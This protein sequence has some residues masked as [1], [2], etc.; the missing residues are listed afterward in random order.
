MAHLVSLRSSLA[1]LLVGLSV[2]LAAQ[3]KPSAQDADVEALMELLNTP[4]KSASKVAQRPMDA[5]SII[6]PVTQDQLRT[7]GWDSINDVLYAQPGFSPSQD[8]DRRTVTARGM[9][10]GWNNNHLLMLIDGV[11]MND[12]LYGTA[13]TWEITPIFMA[14]SLEV[15]RGPGSAL[16]GSNATNG[17]VAI[18]TVSAEEI[19]KPGE[20]RIRMG[21]RQGRQLDFVV[22]SEGDVFSLVAAYARN[23]TN[24][25]EYADYDWSGRTDAAGRLAKFQTWD[26]RSNDYFLGKLEGRGDLKG[27]SFQY[28]H[29][30]WQFGT[31][32]GWYFLTPDFAET[33]KE[34][35]DILVGAY[36][37]EA[38]AWSQEYVLRFQRHN[39]DWNQRYY[40][41][42]PNVYAAGLWEYLNTSADEVFG[43]AQGTRTF[44]KGGSLV[45]GLE[46]SRFSYDGDREHNSNVD[47]HNYD[48]Q[49]NLNPNAYYPWDASNST[50][51][52]RPWLEW[53]KDH[54]V[55]KS[56]LYAQFS[57]GKLLN[58]HFS[59]TLGVRYDKQSSEFTGI[60]TPGRPTES[61]SYSRVSPRLAFIYHGGDT[62]SLKLLAGQAFRTPAP[63]ET[64]GANTFSLASNIR[65]LKPEIIDTVEL[66]SDWTLNHNVNWKVNLFHT[67]FK[68]Q[69]GYS[70]SNYNLSTNLYTLTTQG[71]E[72]ELQFGVGAL[73]G[74]FNGSYAKRVGEESQD[75]KITPMT[76]ETTWA[77]SL[78]FNLGL[79]YKSGPWN[80]GITAHRQGEVKRRDSDLPIPGDAFEGYR[81]TTVGAWTSL[82]LRVGYKLGNGLELEL[83]AKNASDQQG[84]LLKN[85][86]YPFDY[87]TE[88]RTIYLGIRLN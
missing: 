22:G 1:M 32:H 40:P 59:T 5:P 56:G 43:R 83:G 54:P 41:N 31:G 50:Q 16:Y 49:G 34:S 10:E 70:P 65:G 6:S 19:A 7:Y 42:D 27:F 13:Y 86:N 78:T 44:G 15:L 73:H 39:I 46:V 2:P 75:P 29:Q 30:A 48:D 23:S 38:G 68:N 8:Y 62:F 64:F 25:D 17:V 77:P 69:I 14:K 24:G 18:N 37:T 11:P 87:R 74:F 20:A 21:S 72:T 80:F 63:T 4:V 9:Y 45:F 3:A 66:A 36:R 12:N 85:F 51:H 47:L 67:K 88:P 33:M 55:L 84:S 60:D 61:L 58:D 76:D 79:N 57:S 82:D 71:L 35:R 28:H 53:T 81:P 26:R 52:L